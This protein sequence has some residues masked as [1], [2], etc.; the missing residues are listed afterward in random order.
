MDETPA[1]SPPSS[2]AGGCG[3][4]VAARP[5]TWHATAVSESLAGRHF[6][7]I[8]LAI[9]DKAQVARVALS[10]PSRKGSHRRRD[11]SALE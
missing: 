1:A 6:G 7:V 2:P 5:G 10:L 3:G 8:K 11:P 9:P 4:L